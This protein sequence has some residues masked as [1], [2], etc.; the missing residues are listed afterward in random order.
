MEEVVASKSNGKV[1]RIVVNVLL[2]IIFAMSLTTVIMTLN[3][4]EQGIPNIFGFGYL[5]VQSDSME[6]VFKEGDLIFVMAT[7]PTDVF[8]VGDIVTF[9]TLINGVRTLNTHEIITYQTVGETR[10]YTTKGT[11]VPQNDSQTIVAGDIVAKYTNVRLIGFGDV[12]DYIQS[13]VGFLLIVVL[14]LAALFVYQVISFSILMS[15]FAKENRKEEKTKLDLDSLDDAQ[16]AEI[17]RKYLESLKAQE[18]K[19]ETAEIVEE[20]AENTEISSSEEKN[21]V[22]EEK[23][24]KP[25]KAKKAVEVEEV[26]EEN[27]DTLETEK[28]KTQRKP[29]TTKPKE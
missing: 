27:K 9:T 5:S 2:W 1:T 12:F 18:Q 15:K 22:S 20:K 13:S 6:P 8:E 4:T 28:P 19:V 23:V 3:R 11:N 16:K 14:P 7:K 10:Y 29:R 21:E 17:A 26:K 25:K 24:E